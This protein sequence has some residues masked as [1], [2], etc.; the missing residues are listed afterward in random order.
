MPRRKIQNQIKKPADE[1][2]N[3]KI[4]KK[5]KK[6]KVNVKA[7]SAKQRE[8]NL[9][10]QPKVKKDNLLGISRD[11]NKSETEYISKENVF[12]KYVDEGKVE[13]DKRLMMWAGVCFFMVLILFFWI[14][15]IKNIFKINEVGNNNKEE[16]FNWQEISDEFSK[17]MEELKEGLGEIKNEKLEA[18]EV[19]SENFIVEGD[20]N[21]TKDI[22]LQNNDTELSKEEM[23]K[24]K[25]RLKK[26]EEEFD[27]N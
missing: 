4:I 16:R 14:L 6:I 27:I 13:Q 21:E 23:L 25:E 17:T 8:S 22:L 5:L 9:K 3:K 24:L 7:G 19:G 10:V 2:K 18:G 26:L 1:T 12:D 11:W 20:S 15:N